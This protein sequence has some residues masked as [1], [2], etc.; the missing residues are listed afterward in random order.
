MEVDRDTINVASDSGEASGTERPLRRTRRPTA[1]A[2]LNEGNQEIVDDGTAEPNDLAGNGVRRAATRGASASRGR[3]KATEDDDRTLLRTMGKQMKELHE[4]LQVVFNAWKRSELRNKDIQAELRQATNELRTANRELQSMKDELQMVHSDLQALKQ[5]VEDEGRNTQDK[6]GVVAAMTTTQSSPSLTYAEVARTAPNSQPSNI[7]TLTSGGTTPSNFTDTLYCTID[8]SKVENE[9]PT[10]TSVGAIRAMVEN[11]IR[12]SE[13]EATS[14]RCRAVTKDPRNPHRIRI[15]CRT[16]DEHAMV[17]RVVEANLVPGAR[18][19]RDDIYPIRVDSVNRTTVLDENGNIRTGA[20]EA[21]GLEND[22]TVAKVAWLSDKSAA[23]AYGSMVVYLGK[24]ADARKLLNEG[25]FH[26]GGES[27]YTRPFERRERPKQCYNCQEITEH[28]AYQCTKPKICGRCAAAGHSHHECRETILNSTPLTMSEKFRM[29][30]LNVRKQGAVHDSL[31]NDETIRDMMVVAIQEPQ[32]RIIQGRLLTTPMGHQG[33]TKMIPSTHRE[34]RWAIRSM[35]WVRKD[36]EAEQI[37]IESPDLTAAVIQM[38][39]RLIL[40]ASVYVPRDNSCALRSTCDQLR[41][42]I[43]KTR[44]RTGKVVEVVVVGD[45]N[46]HDQLWGGD[47]V[48]MVRQGEG[49]QIVDFMNEF[50]L[51]SLLPRGTKTWQGGDH[52]STIDLVLASEGLSNSLIRCAIHGTEHGSDHRA[53]ETVFDSSVPIAKPVERLLFKNAPWKEINARITNALERTS[54]SGTVQQ[55]TDVLMTVVLEAV[56]TLTPKAK[57][58]PHSKRWWTSDLTQLRR[59]YTYW[60]NRARAER[61]AGVSRVD[62]EERAKGAAKQYHDAIRHQK[63]KH[64]NEFLADNDNIWKAV[65]Y[66]KAGEDEAFGKVPQLVRADK[67]TTT[68]NLEQ[69]EEL[70]STFFPTLPANIEEEGERPQREAVKMPPITMEEVERQLFAAKPW[71]AAGEDGLPAMVWKQIWPSVQHWV[72]DIF[73]TS[74]E[75]GALPRQWRHAKIIPL[76]KPGKDDYTLA[77]AWRPISLLAT[78]GKVLESVMAE[79]IA[80]VV[81]RHGLLPTNHFGARKQRSAEQALLLLQE[82]IYTAWRGHRVLSLVSFDV[83][84]AYNGVC[85]ERLIQRMK[86]RGIP[87]DLLRWVSAFCSDRTAT[88]QINGQLSDSRILPQAGLPQGSPLSPVLF[89][90][91]NAD[92]VQRRIDSNGGAMAF[93]DDFT[94]WVTGKTARNNREGI[95]SIIRDAV[96]W[97]KRSGATFEAEKTAIIHFTRNDDKLDLEPYVIKGQSVE[98]KNHTKILGV[99]MDTRL[100]YKEHI[101]RASSKGLKAALELQRLRGLSPATARQLFTATVA[102]VVD[103]A[104]NIWMHRYKDKL[105]GPIN[106]VQR[107]SAKAIVGTFLTVATCVAEAEAHILTAKERF[108]RKAVKMWTDIH[109]LPETNP[110]RRMTSKMRKFRNAHRSPLFQVAEALKDMPM[111]RIEIINPL[112]LLPWEERLEVEIGEEETRGAGTA[113]TIRVAVSSSARNGVVGVGGAVQKQSGLRDDPELEL[114]SF[115]LGPRS[116]QNP[117]S[118]QLAAMAYALRRSLSD[119]ASERITVVTSN[120]AAV[121]TLRRPHQQSGQEFIRCI[122]DS[123]EELRRNDNTLTVQWTATWEEDELLKQAKAQAREATKEGATPHAQFPAMKSTTL[124]AARSKCSP[125][126]TLPE[127][128]GR[129]SKRVD[130]ALPG[131]HTRQLYDKLSWKE[132]T[133]LAQLRT[134]MARLNGYLHR[135]DAAPSHVC[136]CGQATETVEH[137]LFRCT[138]WTTLRSEML[139]CT[140]TQRGNISFYLGGKSPLDDEK[141]TPNMQAVRATIRFALATGRLDAR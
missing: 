35:L 44:Q 18:V 109:T 54:C 6:L 122:Y 135:I 141:W 62:L 119:V 97:E 45:F 52:T 120:K 129:H 72:L 14:W 130:K 71:K 56:H 87:D 46:R 57:P 140:E 69:A 38:G 132:S 133:T 137:F 11:Q 88:I 103:Y 78:L 118:G 17:K 75:E 89:L 21:F 40:V 80:H 95:E 93:V 92:L 74:L 98:P 131:R 61:R 51:S 37:R 49:D 36:V 67:T 106:R 82:Q 22:T 9:D 4:S 8:T 65:K 26:A 5:Q 127:K 27:G 100:K 24:A 114:F 20:A 58:S 41:Q 108:W 15:A 79:R 42:A 19:L 94:A 139:Q 83:K 112:T 47:E 115:T 1:K 123:V 86:A 77:K 2:R 104:S 63:K 29:M 128:V 124:N 105:I 138:K 39:D 70:L 32:A 34:G 125:E 111:E 99:I 85:K 3:T 117:Y 31:M 76:K 121:L 12:A 16:D 7:R 107:I 73:R 90:F 53:F 28:K 101:A 113:T 33:W 30:Q 25:F 136:A 23:K 13:G 126:R 55:K 64:W 60:R 116:E 50:G 102:P 48:S 91:F 68:N 10:Q 66:L 110:L 96:G 59:I 134:G 81:E 43:A 84:G